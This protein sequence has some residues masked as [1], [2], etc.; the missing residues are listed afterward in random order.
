MTFGFERLI[1][2]W[3]WERPVIFIE[4]LKCES[5]DFHF[6]WIL[7]HSVDIY[8]RFLCYGTTIFSFFKQLNIMYKSTTWYL[9]SYCLAN[10]SSHFLQS[11]WKNEPACHDVAN[12]AVSQN[13]ALLQ[14]ILG[15]SKCFV[16]YL[17][18]ITYFS[19]FNF[20]P[21]CS[22]SLWRLTPFFDV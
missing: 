22:V 21:S 9:R 7:F 17:K 13:L 2:K 5:L 11:F 1:A 18:L 12:R 16:S 19:F 4:L 15:W 6:G 8:V 10:F 20:T 3:T 14:T